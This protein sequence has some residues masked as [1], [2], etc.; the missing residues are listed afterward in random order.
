MK[1]PP[2]RARPRTERWIALLAWLVFLSAVWG[3]SDVR[4]RAP[5]VAAARAT[6]ADAPADAVLALT[7]R[8]AEG[9]GG[10]TAS[11][12]VHAPRGDRYFEVARRAIPLGERVELA[13]LPR[14]EVWL[15]VE[16]AEHARGARRLELVPGTQSLELELEAAHALAVS[17]SD[18]A[19]NPLGGATVL[20]SGDDPLPHGALVRADG[21]AHFPRLD[22]P[23][24][25]V[26]VAA[27]GFETV[28]RHDVREDLAVTL[29][30]LGELAVEVEHGDGTPA[31]GATVI[32]V[33]TRL[34]PARRATTDASGSARIAGLLAGS[35]DLRAT[36][37]GEVSDPLLGFT[38]APSARE[39]VTLRLQPGRFVNVVVTD[40]DEEF[41][42][43]VPNADVVLVE[44][45]LG[46]FPERGR[47]GTDGTVRLG[48]LPVAPATVSARADGFVARSGIPVPE[49][50]DEAIRIG[51]VRAARLD[52][53][54]VDTGGRPI[55]GATIEV[56]GTDLWGMP[57][58]DSPG[59]QRFQSLHFAWAL[60]GPVPL[61]PAGELG[62]MPGPVPPIP[63]AGADP[64]LY[65]GLDLG[66][67]TE[68]A[69][70]SW[71]S[72]VD[73]RFSAAPVTPGRVRAFVRHPA[74]VEGISEPVVV[75]PGAT[76]RVRVVLEVGGNLEGRLVDDRGFPVAGA[77]IE[78]VAARGTAEVV[79]F[80]A[81]DGTFAFAAIPAEVT[82]SLA[83]PEEP[84][85]I[86]L[87]R[88]LTVPADRTTKVELV[89]PAARE[90][91]RV[92]VVDGEGQPV[93]TAQVTALGADPAAPY[94]ETR[95]TDPDGLAEL[96]D[97][98]GRA[99]TFVVEA[100]R[101]LRATLEVAAAAP[102]LRVTLATGVIVTGRVT[103]V[104]GRFPAEGA[105]V[106][107]V[108]EGQRLAAVADRD[109]RY[110]LRDVP[111]G[112]VHLIVSHAG[113]ATEERD[114]TVE[115][116]GR[117]DRPRELP[118]IDLVEPGAV[119]GVVRDPAGKPV[120]GAR[121]AVGVSPSFLPV[122]KLPP[123]VAVTDSSGRFRLD[124]L[125]PGALE[126]EAYAA[127]VG[128]GF[129][130]TTVVEGK[131]ASGLVIV[132]DEP[133]GEDEPPAS[134]NV[135]ATLGERGELPDVVVV[136]VAAD[137]EA[138]RAGLRPGDLVV[139]V[140]GVEVVDMAD[141][142]ARLSGRAGTDVVVA[143]ERD[144]A[145]R[146][147]RVAREA[148]RR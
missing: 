133:A 91:V 12:R 103:T 44:D 52:G 131:T 116:T 99:L 73:G 36:L 53:E 8:G 80:T 51:L 143:V 69:R 84:G 38:L 66:P 86:V 71:V 114:V 78:I 9:S 134:G 101:L 102:E 147:L 30:N 90:P 27:P 61:V 11:L 26:T 140:D 33:G 50:S 14:G 98:R 4:P 5:R 79:T 112:R 43:V 138:E 3:L 46:P 110:Q 83:R 137:S 136:H 129:G 113:H 60:G 28:T 85:R 94:R 49:A 56:V 115:R 107:L 63:R 93:D 89:L 64:L 10:R 121:V 6:V 145:L 70:A 139:E 18:E 13:G 106:T 95:F 39:S 65:A 20:V 120:I 88:P 141:A 132:L 135:A 108:T 31:V 87:T 47:T 45:G 76:A 124:A 21:R 1:R 111:P 22:A 68:A 81:D 57:V 130:T 40:G 25:V 82:V 2:S 105:R 48:P 55:E 100:P 75:A 16:A 32:L 37:G 59:A 146:R 128:R 142:R 125:A 97:A 77:R 23:P 41:A 15:L 29:R 109:G 96:P 42:V 19:G 123:G 7:V 144:G 58:A 67:D 122:G 35:Y 118:A 72:G 74:Y 126:L 34:W 17:V 117:D 127:D 104:R 92:R 24:W 62:V 54:V 119:E 148:V